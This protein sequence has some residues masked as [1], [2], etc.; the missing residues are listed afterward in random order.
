MWIAI[1]PLSEDFG[2][3]KM[4]ITHKTPRIVPGIYYVSFSYCIIDSMFSKF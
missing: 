4:E 3:L 1:P 2:E